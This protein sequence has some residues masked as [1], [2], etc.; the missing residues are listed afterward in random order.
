[1]R[2][3]A[4]RAVYGRYGGAEMRPFHANGWDWA[5]RSRCKIESRP[6]ATASVRTDDTAEVYFQSAVEVHI[7]QLVSD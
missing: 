7:C 5:G 4:L 1:M 6:T 3:G 2:E